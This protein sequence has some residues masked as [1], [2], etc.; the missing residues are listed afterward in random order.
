VLFDNLDETASQKINEKVKIIAR[1]EESGELLKNLFETNYGQTPH[2]II[3]SE[4]IQRHQSQINELSKKYDNSTVQKIYQ[5]NE[6]E[7]MVSSFTYTQTTAGA[8]YLNLVRIYVG[9]FTF[10]GEIGF[11]RVG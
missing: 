8:L 9:D 3:L 11:T 2:I 4:L 7:L 5:P 10:T 1:N 6:Y